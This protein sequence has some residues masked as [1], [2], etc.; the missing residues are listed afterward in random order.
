MK[1]ILL[2]GLSVLTIFLI[3]SCTGVDFKWE[4]HPYV[5]D[6]TEE[7]IIDAE[8]G[9]IHF[10]DIVIEDFIAF[11]SQNIADLKAEIDRIN[12]SENDRVRLDDLFKELIK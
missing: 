8:G 10:S 4:A 6:I 3:V 9:Y 5:F 11:P 12:M 2:L 1:K 7:K